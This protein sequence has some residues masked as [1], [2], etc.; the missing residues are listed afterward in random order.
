[1]GLKLISPPVTTPVTLAEAKAHLRVVDSDDDT[2]IAG[3]I[4]AATNS[5]EAFLGRALIDQTWDLYLDSFPSNTTHLEIKIP[6]PPL[7]EVTQIAYDDSNGDEQIIATGNYYVDTVSEFGW[8]VPQGGL[9][10]PAPID[11]INSVRVRF[12]AGYLDTNSPPGNAVPGDIK[13]AVLLTIG[14]FYEQRDS[15]VVGTVVYQL[16]WGVEQLLRQHRVLLGMA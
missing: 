7:I 10:W 2:L 3:Y 4:A 15:M 13:S 12:R 1:M 14:S 9:S 6:K 16:P 8:V 5:T 11:A